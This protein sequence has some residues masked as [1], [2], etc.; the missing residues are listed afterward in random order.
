MSM[1]VKNE[2]NVT[3]ETDE[4]EVKAFQRDKE[5]AEFMHRVETGALSDEEKADWE[6]MMSSN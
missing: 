4:Y 1:D 5:F 6:E 3:V 2:N